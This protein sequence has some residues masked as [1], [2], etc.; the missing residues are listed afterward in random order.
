MCLIQ[1]PFLDE[2]SSSLFF[3]NKKIYGGTSNKSSLPILFANEKT[4]VLNLSLIKMFECGFHLPF[5]HSTGYAQ[6]ITAREDIEVIVDIDNE[7]PP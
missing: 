1:L 5:C 7:E 3:F 6:K 4:C 2:I